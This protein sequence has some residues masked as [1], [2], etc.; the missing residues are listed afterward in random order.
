MSL[1]MT[2]FSSVIPASKHDAVRRALRTAFDTDTLD[3][4]SLLTGGLSS[5]LVYKIGV[6]GK[7]CVLRIVMQVEAFNDPL[8]QTLCMTRAADA[9]IAPRVY[10]ANAEDALAITEWVEQQPLP[11]AETLIVP[12]AQRIQA[13]HALPAFP[14]LINFLDGVDLFIENFKAS[15]LL[16]PSATEEHFRLY[17]QIQSVIRATILMWCRATT[18]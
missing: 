13:I 10:Y 11:P 9:G 16:P 2:D 3:S 8:R 5:S 18:I 4:I 15:Q 14:P 17:A 12:L 7:A 6:A 1:Q